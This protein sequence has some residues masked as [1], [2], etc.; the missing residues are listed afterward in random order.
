ME[1]IIRDC[2]NNKISIAEITRRTK[3][4]YFMLLNNYS[5][6]FEKVPKW[7]EKKEQGILERHALKLLEKEDNE[8]FDRKLNKELEKVE[9]KMTRIKGTSNS[10][11]TRKNTDVLYFE[12]VKYFNKG[13][14][15]KSMLENTKKRCKKFLE[16]LKNKNG[17]DEQDKKRVEEIQIIMEKLN[18]P[19]QKKLKEPKVKK[20]KEPKVKKLKEP[21]VKKL[22]EPKTKKTVSGHELYNKL[23]CKRNDTFIYQEHYVEDNK[24]FE[25]K[26]FQNV[27][28]KYYFI[29]SIN[30]AIYLGF[31][32]WKQNKTV[33]RKIFKDEEI[34]FKNGIETEKTKVMVNIEESDKPQ[35]RISIDLNFKYFKRTLQAVFSSRENVMESERILKSIFTVEHNEYFKIGDQ[36]YR[37]TKFRDNSFGSTG[38][39]SFELEDFIKESSRQ[40]IKDKP[41]ETA[42]INN[43]NILISYDCETTE[44]CV[45]NNDDYN[46][47]QQPYLLVATINFNLP[48]IAGNDNEVWYCEHKN[49]K[50]KSTI[51]EQFF[52]RLRN[53]IYEHQLI[54][55]PD[56][57]IKIFG[58]NNNKFDNNFI[59]DDFIKDGCIIKVSERNNKVGQYDILFRGVRVHFCD[60]MKWV[61]D[62]SLHEAC[63]DYEIVMKKL[64]LNILKY[65]R[66]CTENGEIVQECTEKCFFS[67]G[68]WPL[69]EKLTLKKELF[70]EK[71]KQLRI[72]DYVKK[73]CAY[74]TFSVLELF[75]KINKVFCDICHY[76]S[77]KYTKIKFVHKTIFDLNSP[78]TFAGLLS[79]MI[80]DWNNEKKLLI[81]NAE[82]F[83]FIY[84]TYFG[85]RVDYAFLG[86]YK[87]QD[88]SICFMD[89]TSEYPLAMMGLYPSI[90]SMDDIMY[91]EDLNIKYFQN[92]IDWCQN[93]R[94]D[95]FQKQ[96]L[97]NFEFLKP[98][99]SF[100]G[101][102]MCNI[103]APQDK[104]NLIQFSAI[105]TKIK[106]DQK[107]AYTNV[108]QKM[109]ALNSVQFKN[110][111]LT[112][113]KIELLPYKHN[114][115]FKKIDYVFKSFIG[116]LGELKTKSK[117]ENNKT[118]AKLIKL[119]LNSTAGKMAQKPYDSIGSYEFIPQHDGKTIYLAN[120]FKN[121]SWFKSKHYLATFITSEANWILYS[122]LY[123]LQLDYIYRKEP[124]EYR[125]GTCLYMDTDSI[126]F[127]KR[128]VNQKY[129]KF[130]CSEELGYYEQEKCDFY[131]T[132]KEKYSISNKIDRMI[133]LA[134]KSYALLSGNKIIELKLKGIHREEM[135]T[136]NNYDVLKS[137][138]AEKPKEI[139]FGGLAMTKMDVSDY[140]NLVM[141]Q[142]YDFLP[143]QNDKITK[144]FSNTQKMPNKIIF[145]TQLKK[146]LT[147]DVN[148]NVLVCKNKE[149]YEKNK[150]DLEM[151][152]PTKNFL[153]FYK[154]P[155]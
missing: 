49:L 151:Q 82:L 75:A 90:K 132:W 83:R 28:N 125:C 92:I 9:K 52:E 107:I 130:I 137:I 79:G 146:T 89:V 145:Q 115:V 98:L 106:D 74:D 20:L 53:F 50:T 29:N 81:N 21:I 152:N 78:A 101:F 126:A 110:L 11:D 10:I 62:M 71:T 42:L 47:N 67:M 59:I 3:L 153:C 119:F 41:N 32:D 128:L 86:E 38:A 19:K 112:G 36:F 102:F 149:V 51:G 40:T 117:E 37:C 68:E 105:P 87:S 124:M 133:I 61:P 88:E 143:N 147:R 65:N 30:Q 144:C 33:T 99:D 142:D 34:W 148:E 127:D 139:R 2:I 141:P 18:K 103:Y 136:F 69:R 114:I 46:K 91:G 97:D 63:E 12:I 15:R 4:S 94:E 16:L 131:T 43:W 5:H 113:F 121:E 85:G 66:M 48:F 111:I 150:E 108:D 135:K 140:T 123:R 44:F 31:D 7:F 154:S 104:Y 129:Y 57:E 70:N 138:V 95:H 17:I 58:Y 76:M 64:N 26:C 122:V 93:K 1:D 27:Y 73:Y 13:F 72:Y 55:Q 56:L 22:K 100:R 24:T 45:P 120:K 54:K 77:S 80:M 109:R 155:Y 134:K 60:L 116:E 8:S 35:K 14:L 25:E 84:S 96:M 23:K 6:L 118:K 39:N